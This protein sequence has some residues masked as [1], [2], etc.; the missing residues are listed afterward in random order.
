MDNVVFPKD[1][2]TDI[3]VEN[4]YATRI[5]YENS[6]LKQN[7]VRTEAGIFIRIFDGSRW[8]YSATTD[9]EHVQRTLDELSKMA[10]PNPGILNHPIIKAMEVNRGETRS[11]T[12]SDCRK[13]DRSEKQ[14]LLESYLPVVSGFSEIALC[15]L[16]YLDR[17]LTKRIVT[18]LGTDI[19]Y[20]KQFMSIVV[21]YNLKIEGRAPFDG[22]FFAMGTR[23]S[24]IDHG[25]AELAEKIKK[26]ICF[27]LNA[28][29][30]EPGVYTCVL[31]PEAAG[32]F[33]HESFGHK[34][35]A[36]FM[37]G[38]E[39]MLREW[40][41]G[42]AV[43]S[44]I[45]SIIETGEAEGNGYTPY[46][47]EGTK[48][49]KNYIIKEGKLVGRLHSA[50]TAADLSEELT[51]NARAVSF[52]YE[53]I[54][55]MTTTYIDKGTLSLD[56]L[57]GG[58]KL[59]IFIDQTKHGSGMS[60][61]TIAPNTA[62]MIRDGKLAEPVKISVI[63]GNVM[64]TLGDIDGLSDELVMLSFP[65]GGCGKMEQFPLP[66]G[67]GGPHVRVNGLTVQ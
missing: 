10:A 13:L 1:L 34:S 29:P 41:L 46:D 28:V 17:H 58:V 36:D 26:D 9:L 20:D 55:R 56:E 40:E 23:L 27:T 51:G 32:I 24:D 64:K 43:G 35:E 14:K 59:G 66:V 12:D 5:L 11:F 39:T 42:K 21:A 15:R 19:S 62:Y 57:F 25:H 6:E 33:A 45:L 37:V 30:V 18:S 38:D 50:M 67:F 60:T 7:K 49:R 2:Y 52:E 47:D 54:V 4:I 16:S 22:R 63:S 65:V 8:Y 3:R 44:P 53:P 61:F 31:S 48:A